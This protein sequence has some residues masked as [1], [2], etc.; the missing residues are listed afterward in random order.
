MRTDLFVSAY[1]HATLPEVLDGLELRERLGDFAPGAQS[2]SPEELQ[3]AFREAG[4]A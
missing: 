1:P 2:M 4:L 3:L